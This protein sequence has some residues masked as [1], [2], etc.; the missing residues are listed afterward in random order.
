MGS[1]YFRSLARDSLR[2]KWGI[3]ILAALL[4][5]LFGAL[6]TG[7]S[8]SFEYQSNEDTWQIVSRL[9]DFVEKYL[10]IAVSLGAVLSVV[11]LILGGVIQLGYCKFLLNMEDGR[12]ATI[13]DLFSQF[14][15]F[16][17]AFVMNLLRGIYIFLWSLLFIIPGIVA[18][19]KYAMAPFILLEKPYLSPNEAI[20]QSKEMMRGEKG[21]LFLLDLSF[22]GWGLLCAL[23]L[24]IG[25]LWLNP[26]KNAS[27]AAF[28]RY[29]YPNFAAQPSQDP[30]QTFVEE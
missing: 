20:T 15:R 16:G 28:Y 27:Y 4:A 10:R 5:A 23:T 29:L 2:G 6:V 13:G 30:P 9:P 1:S 21:A 24:G 7:S 8:I 26:Y 12:Q 18:A 17:A 25:S 11:Q 3:A 22:I 19:Y 14:H